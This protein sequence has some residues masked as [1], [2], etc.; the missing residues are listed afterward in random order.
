MK[1]YEFDPTYRRT[2]STLTSNFWHLFVFFVWGKPFETACRVH[3]LQIQSKLKTLECFKGENHIVYDESAIRCKTL[4][5]KSNHRIQQRFHEFLFT[6]KS[7][8]FCLRFLFASHLRT[9]VEF[10]V[11]ERIPEVFFAILFAVLMHSCFFPGVRHCVCVTV[12]VSVHVCVCVC[13]RHVCLWCAPVSVSPR[14]CCKQILSCPNGLQQL[15]LPTRTSSVEFFLIEKPHATLQFHIH[16]WISL[17]ESKTKKKAQAITLWC[18]W[19]LWSV[20][21]VAVIC[22]RCHHCH[23]QGLSYMPN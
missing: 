6:T 13:A 19:C 18:R 7:R 5:W 3:T 23:P 8:D 15:G 9:S 10:Y 21:A 12:C 11:L 14:E 2:E 20:S 16:L 4:N 1:K 22:H 17:T